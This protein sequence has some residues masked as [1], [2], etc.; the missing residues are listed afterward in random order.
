MKKSAKRIMLY[1]VIFIVVMIII[2]VPLVDKTAI[3]DMIANI[4]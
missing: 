4:F 1:V 2:F 3:K